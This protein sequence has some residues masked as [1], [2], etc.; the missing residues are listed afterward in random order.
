MR[1]LR[2]PSVEKFVRSFERVGIFGWLPRGHYC[3]NGF[4]KR[5]A[6]LFVLCFVCV[7]LK[8][9]L[10]GERAER[11]EIPVSFVLLN[12][13]GFSES[14]H[15][16]PH[17]VSASDNFQFFP[18]DVHLVRCHWLFPFENGFNGLISVSFGWCE[19]VVVSGISEFEPDNKPARRKSIGV[20]RLSVDCCTVDHLFL[21]PLEGF[22][23]FDFVQNGFHFG[24]NPASFLSVGG[25][26]EPHGQVSDRVSF[27][28]E[29]IVCWVHLVVP[30]FQD[31]FVPCK[32]FEL[33]E[34]GRN[35]PGGK[36][37][38][39]VFIPV[40][41]PQGHDTHG[42]VVHVIGRGGFESAVSLFPGHKLSFPCSIEEQSNDC[43]KVEHHYC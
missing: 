31:V 37:Q 17:F 42:I 32:V 30:H 11:H 9:P 27:D 33:G 15:D 3:G 24:V 6:L 5:I 23:C 18:A 41:V 26:F 13:Q 1:L 22:E 20:D 43:G 40:S 10:R 16:C 19:A 4:N 25:V 38:R 29:H 8:S 39:A 21:H 36:H 35:A 34:F 28:P 12:L 14:V 2:E 7:A